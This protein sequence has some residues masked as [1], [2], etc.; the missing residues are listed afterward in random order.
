MKIRINSS[1]RY[2]NHDGRRRGRKQPQNNAKRFAEEDP[3][4]VVEWLSGR[5]TAGRI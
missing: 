5:P 4:L 2:E 3:L 1:I